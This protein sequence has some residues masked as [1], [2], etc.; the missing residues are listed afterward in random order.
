[1]MVSF[2]RSNAILRNILSCFV[3]SPTQSN[4]LLHVRVLVSQG[5]HTLKLLGKI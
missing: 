4:G 1:M 5:D 2:A 3:I